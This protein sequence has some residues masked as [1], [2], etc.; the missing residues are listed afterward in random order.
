MSADPGRVVRVS[1]AYET[2]ASGEVG[3]APRT[4]QAVALERGSKE[5]SRRECDGG[6][7]LTAFCLWFCSRWLRIM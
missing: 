1:N 3:I 7:P 6:G 5:S 2:L 4:R